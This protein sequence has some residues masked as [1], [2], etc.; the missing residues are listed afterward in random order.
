L[1]DRLEHGHAESL[2]DWYLLSSGQLPGNRVSG[3]WLLRVEWHEHFH[4]VHARIPLQPD[5]SD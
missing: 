1:R 2:L 4:L 5:G 3:I